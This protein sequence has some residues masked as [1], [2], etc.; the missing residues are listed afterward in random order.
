MHTLL[1]NLEQLVGIPAYHA[2]LQA[3]PAPLYN[4]GNDHGLGHAQLLGQGLTAQS[5]AVE[6]VADEGANSAGIGSRTEGQE[7][8]RV[9]EC[10]IEINRSVFR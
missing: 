1:S 7:Q 6:E 5:I 8:K 4:T 10:C 2:I 9:I 3:A